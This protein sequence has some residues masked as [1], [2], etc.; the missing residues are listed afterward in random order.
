V[1][2]DYRAEH[3]ASIGPVRRRERNARDMP[4][5][6]RAPERVTQHCRKAVLVVHDRL[7]ER[8]AATYFLCQRG[9]GGAATAAFSAQQ[10]DAQRSRLAALE[11]LYNLVDRDSRHSV[12]FKLSIGT[13]QAQHAG[14]E[15]F[16][17]DSRQA[18]Y[19]DRMY[20]QS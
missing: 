2:I 15:S 12:L 3:F 1:S 6:P 17:G 19:Q 14:V 16:T 13:S 11:S 5:E 4:R 20:T 9:S 7:D 8:E 10:N 18:A